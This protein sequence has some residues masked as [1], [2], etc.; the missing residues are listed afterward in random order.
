MPEQLARQLRLSI[1]N[2]VN[3]K[4]SDALSHRDGLARLIAH[5]TSGVASTDI[6]FAERTLDEL[7]RRS[8]SH[9]DNSAGKDNA[10]HCKA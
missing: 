3:A 5:R 4:V 8:L 6:R 7:F 2:L 10:E 9:A 1:E